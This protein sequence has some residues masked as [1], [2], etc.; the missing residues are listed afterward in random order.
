MQNQIEIK[1]FI[2]KPGQKYITLQIT[3]IMLH[4]AMR[5]SSISLGEKIKESI[6]HS[7]NVRMYSPLEKPSKKEQ[8]LFAIEIMKNDPNFIKAVQDY[9]SEGYKVLI[10][11]PD[12][13]VPIL[14][15]EDTGQYLESKNGKRFLRGIAKEKLK[16]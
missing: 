8:Q 15:G 4:T 13:G 9:E 6:K 1:Q 11:L 3:D 10:S 2:P 7:E 12:E 5:R 14:V 16:S